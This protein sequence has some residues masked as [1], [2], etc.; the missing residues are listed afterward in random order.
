MNSFIGWIGGKNHLK[1]Q[2]ISLIP[3]NIERY[4]EVFGGAG[5][6]LFGKEQYPK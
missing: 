2:I 6:V 3:E 1:K 5:W 4:I